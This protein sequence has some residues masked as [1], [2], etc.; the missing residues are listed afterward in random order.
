MRGPK[1]NRNVD[2]RGQLAMEA[3]PFGTGI[4]TVPQAS[5]M[6]RVNLG[7]VSRWFRGYSYRPVPGA[8]K[9]NKPPVGRTQR[10]LPLISGERAMSF[11]EFEELVV[12]TAFVRKGL[13]LQRVRVAAECLMTEYGVD[14]PFAY[15]RIF[16]DGADI[17][18]SMENEAK[19]PDLIKLT[20][21]DRLQIRAGRIDAPF[22]EEIK[23]SSKAPFVAELYYPCG[24]DIPIVVNPN[25]AFGAPIVEG[26]R[27]T[28]ETIAAMVRGSSIEQV[29]EEYELSARAVKAA[30]AYASSLT[31]P[32]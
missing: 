32:V 29:A 2:R 21:K 27:V 26:T 1:E 28:V 30:V 24:Q 23:F 6:L 17:F 19:A 15:R 8:P 16:T 12:V 11:L 22:V 3:I 31:S 9:R 7:T 13:P 18:A 14:R 10:D 5:R 20:R 4:F 25:I